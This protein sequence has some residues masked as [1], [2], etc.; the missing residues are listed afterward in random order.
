MQAGKEQQQ[1]LYDAENYAGVR[2]VANRVLPLLDLLGVDSAERMELVIL[3]ACAEYKNQL[4]A[5]YWEA[6]RTALDQVN[7][8]QEQVG[9]YNTFSSLC[10]LSLPAARASVAP[11]PIPTPTSR[12]LP[13]VTPISPQPDPGGACTPQR[14][15]ALLEPAEGASHAAGYGP[16]IFSWEG[17]QL[18]SEQVWQVTF[19]GMV[20]TDDG[21]VYCAP[22][23]SN[24][25]TCHIPDGPGTYEWRVEI[26]LNGQP[27]PGMM[28]SSRSL[29][30][31]AQ[32]QDCS[33]DTD[34]DGV[35]NCRDHCPN[36]P[37]PDRGERPG[38]PTE[39]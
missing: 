12:P 16:V 30:A 7:A 31:Q 29:I 6:A 32:G 36:E 19:N 5:G 11:T 28:S 3:Q 15:T 34:G 21:R 13:G 38:C 35:P 37:G 27:M 20:A 18:C 17:G 4:E 23:R 24:S 22:T 9:F 10:H 8:Y 2:D 14:P 1:R 25:T 33:I 26:R 39:Q